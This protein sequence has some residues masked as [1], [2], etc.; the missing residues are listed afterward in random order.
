MYLL[1]A[2][3]EVHIPVDAEEDV[4]LKPELYHPESIKVK[5]NI[6]FKAVQSG[7]TK[8]KCVN[9]NRRE[10]AD[11]YTKNKS[12][13]QEFGSNDDTEV[14]EEHSSDQRYYDPNKI[15]QSKKHGSVLMLDNAT[16][17][18]LM[19]KKPKGR[20]L[21]SREREQLPHTPSVSGSEKVRDSISEMNLD[22]NVTPKQNKT[23]KIQCDFTVS[24][25]ELRASSKSV[26]IFNVFVFEHEFTPDDKENEAC[27]QQIWFNEFWGTHP[28]MIDSGVQ[29]CC[30]SPDMAKR[31]QKYLKTDSK[32]PIGIRTG[33]KLIHVDT[34]LALN[35]FHITKALPIGMVRF[36]ILPMLNHDLLIGIFGYQKPQYTLVYI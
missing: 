3:K 26:S 12:G 36:W 13:M 33:A 30:C 8:E 27:I 34:Y 29:L 18:A 35:P 11:D 6:N 16:K 17:S 7:G 2:R 25:G 9:Y 31:Y 15:G 10:I 20:K 32:N 21:S 19:V 14:E 22:V 24:S 23:D 1:T 5:G 28:C 4:I